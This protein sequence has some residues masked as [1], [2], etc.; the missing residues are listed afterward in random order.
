MG[1]RDDVDVKRQIPGFTET[2]GAS[3]VAAW[4]KGWS[5]FETPAAHTGWVMTTR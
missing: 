1:M 5:R 3:S 4:Q 2:Y